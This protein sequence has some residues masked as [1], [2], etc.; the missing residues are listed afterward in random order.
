MQCK[1]QRRPAPCGPGATVSTLLLSPAQACCIGGPHGLA[2]H[3]QM[4]KK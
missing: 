1:F 4:L 3:P 2:H